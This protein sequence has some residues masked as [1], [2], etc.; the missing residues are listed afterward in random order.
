MNVL[1]DV[2]SIAPTKAQALAMLNE[3]TRKADNT[4]DTESRD[5]ASIGRLMEAALD[6]EASQY[7]TVL[8][9]SYATTS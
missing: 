4:V 9:L 5:W 1:I 8:I 6:I 2:W 3:R 7:V